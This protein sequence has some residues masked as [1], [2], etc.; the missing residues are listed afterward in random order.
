MTSTT[1][2]STVTSRALRLA[3]V[4]AVACALVR[5]QT[6]DAAAQTGYPDSYLR[7]AGDP[8]KQGE[9][10]DRTPP[11]LREVTFKQRLGEQLPLDARLTDEAGAS[12]TLGRYFTGQK[13]V[14][15][16]FVYY[17]CPMLCTQ[18]MNGLSASL[19]GL[20]SF[21]VGQEFD[22]I[23]V[24]IDPGE[25][26]GLAAAKKESYVQ[27]LGQPS[28]ESGWHFLV[29]EEPEIRAL[30]DAIGF[31]YFYD[32]EIDEYAHP[33]GFVV[34]TPAGRVS[35]YFIDVVFPPI[36]LRLA[37][38]ESSEGR[39]GNVIDAITL[40]CYQHDPVS[41]KYGLV[42][43][44]VVRLLGGLTLLCLGGFIV[45]ALRRERRQ[46]SAEAHA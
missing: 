7:Y 9:A 35:R 5:L 1:R 46:S 3:V 27:A 33:G 13:P 29:G 6:G 22:V 25:S 39:I 28:A 38:V 32:A 18:V 37:L 31:R 36:D 15:L 2:H 43:Q 21:T 10:A 34:L 41:G 45:I 26:P 4:C 14:V 23:T 19:R 20:E 8:Q 40:L 42:V 24:S 17:R 16:A 44:N 11:Q 12:V 30:A